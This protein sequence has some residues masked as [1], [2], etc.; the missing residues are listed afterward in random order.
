[1]LALSWVAAIVAC[2][3]YG[4]GS[5]LQSVGAR[6]TAHVA[7]VTG[8]ALILL[9][10]AVPAGPGLRR[11]RLRW[12]TWWRCSELPLFLVQSIIT[13]SVGV[14]AVIA[15]IRGDRLSWRDW[16]SLAV[17]GVGLVLLS[18]TANAE[19]AVRVSTVSQWVILA[20]AVLPVAVGLVGLRLPDRSSALV[21]AAGGRPGLHRGRGGL[22][23]DQR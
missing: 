9:Q 20:S 23:R 12:P 22:P 2:L 4:V 16:A 14:T 19:S 13:A 21:L 17:L 7:G 15:G 5:V 1:M 11:A 18:L 3:G 6:R 8:V 10:A